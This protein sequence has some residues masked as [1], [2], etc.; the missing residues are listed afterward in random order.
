MVSGQYYIANSARVIIGTLPEKFYF[1]AELGGGNDFKLT[2]S[3]KDYDPEL[4]KNGN[5]VICAGTE[6]GGVL[7]NKTIDTKRIESTFTGISFRGLFDKK[8]V[9]PPYGYDYYTIRSLSLSSAIKRLYGNCFSFEGTR[10]NSDNHDY[11][12]INEQRYK[13]NLLNVKDVSKISGSSTASCSYISDSQLAFSWAGAGTGEAYFDLGQPLEPGRNYLFSFTSLSS[14]SGTNLSS[15]VLILCRSTDGIN[16]RGQTAL[17]NYSSPSTKSTGFPIEYGYRYCIKVTFAVGGAGRTSLGQP[18]IERVYS[19]SATPSGYEYH[20]SHYSDGSSTMSGGEP[21]YPSYQLNRYCSLLEA[22]ENLCDYRNVLFRMRVTGYIITKTSNTNLGKEAF[23]LRT[24]FEEPKRTDENYEFTTDDTDFVIQ[25]KQAEYNYILALG[26]GNLKDR[27][28]KRY[29]MNT[30]TGKLTEIDHIPIADNA[31]VYLY[32][33]GS[34]ESAEELEIYSQK[35]ALELIDKISHKMTLNEGIDY[36]V[37]DI[38][39]AR[40]TMTNSTVEEPIRKKIIKVSNGVPKIS[41]SI[42]DDI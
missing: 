16:W 21:Y 17:Y 40:E 5:Y 18:M 13:L 36:D 23:Y 34:V 28:V 35:K 14:I 33:Y 10:L 9:E 42:G 39:T 26:S 19:S 31:K 20:Q 37:G 30:T 2:I 38:V 32:D 27:L 24:L 41:Y 6:V 29:S 3:V 15:L 12:E 7:N 22:V 8:I 11:V 1:D 25:E 4:Y